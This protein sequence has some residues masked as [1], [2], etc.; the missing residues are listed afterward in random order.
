M[1]HNSYLFFILKRTRTHATW[2]LYLV[3]LKSFGKTISRY[4]KLVNYAVMHFLLWIKVP[5]TTISNPCNCG[6]VEMTIIKPF[7][8]HPSML[9]HWWDSTLI[10]SLP[11]VS[12][13][14]EWQSKPWGA[15]AWYW[16]IP[17]TCFFCV[18]VEF[19]I[20]GSFYSILYKYAIILR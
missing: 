4:V 2:S 13:A 16:F 6:M 18:W 10:F 11:H 14:L 7:S 3:T 20:L 12:L 8:I 19:K 5:S 9:S 17:A 1:H 15:F